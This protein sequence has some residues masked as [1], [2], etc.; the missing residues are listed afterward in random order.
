MYCTTKDIMKNAKK[1]KK[2]WCLLSTATD[3]IVVEVIAY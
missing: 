1:H 2:Y 3:G